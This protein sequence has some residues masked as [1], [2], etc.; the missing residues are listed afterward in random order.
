MAAVGGGSLSSEGLA[1][2]PMQEN[3]LTRGSMASSA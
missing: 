1:A 3:R 2:V